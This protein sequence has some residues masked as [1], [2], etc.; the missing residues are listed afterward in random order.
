MAAVCSAWILLATAAYCDAPHLPFREGEKLSFSIRYGPVRAGVATLEVREKV[1]CP[2]G[3]CFQVVSEA[4]STMPFSLFFEVRDRV[5]SLL[6]AQEVY[7]WRYEK[8]LKEGHYEKNE[9]VIFDQV[10]NTATYPDGKIIEV[11]ARVQDVLTSLYYARTLELAVGASVF[12]DN[13]ADEKNYPLEV[14]VLGTETVEVPAGS[15][16]CFI[17]EPILKASG[18]FQHEGRLT[19]WMS[20]DPTRIPV[21]MKSKVIIGSIDAVLTEVLIEE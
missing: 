19:V 2:G 1:D 4:R 15:Y 9:V 21:M 14:R 12:I 7:T 16:E 11:P 13:H 8:D 5:E 3:E 20:T 18:I 17:L 6:D 10:K